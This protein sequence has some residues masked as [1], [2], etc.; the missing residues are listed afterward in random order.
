MKKL[1]K[2]QIPQFAALCVLSAGLFGYFVV[3]LVTPSPAAAG[4]RPAQ[5]LAPASKQ[6]PAGIAKPATDVPAKDPKVAL[7]PDAPPTED[8]AQVP[9]PTAGMHDPF[10][11]GYVDPATIPATHGAPALPPPPG[12][13]AEQMASL[14]QPVPAFLNA[15]APMNLKGFPVQPLPPTSSPSAPGLPA[16]PPAV[17]LVAAAPAPPAWTVTGV[18]QSDGEQVAI[19]RSG[20]ARRIVHTG[21]F[22]DSVYR[23]VSVT[24]T[25]VVLRHGTVR[26]PLI[27]GAVKDAPTKNTLA[28]SASN[29]E[30]SVPAALPTAPTAVPTAL[31]PMAQLQ[32]D[33]AA[34]AAKPNGFNL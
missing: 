2:K 14:P 15:P 29:S 12:K 21:D 1:E 32:N 22:V 34:E 30:K 18:L 25:S 17:P 11:I 4:T 24:R 20:A 10:V 8:D 7:T 6:A 23:V 16:A 33:A 31:P 19:L 26:Y 27:L 28:K 9:V 5:A 13:P 3:R